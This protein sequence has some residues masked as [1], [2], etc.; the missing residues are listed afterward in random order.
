[1]AQLAEEVGALSE[2][3]QQVAHLKASVAQLDAQLNEGLQALSHRIGS[4]ELALSK[5]KESVERAMILTEEFKKNLGRLFARL[6]GV[7]ERL[8]LLE[9]QG[10][11][12][13]G[14]LGELRAW[15][16]SQLGSLAVRLEELESRLMGLKELMAQ[17]EG[18]KG[19]FAKL[20]EHQAKLAARQEHNEAQL[21]Q[22]KERLVVEDPRVAELERKVD[23]L[24]EKLAAVLIEVEQSRLAITELEG[25]LEGLREEIKAEVLAEIPPWPQVPTMEELRLVAEEVAAEQVKRAQAQAEAAQGLAIVALLA[26][27]AAIAVSLLL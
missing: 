12:L 14:E 22:L 21:A 11:A 8:S 18:L 26:G 6:E 10:D 23:K 1:V 27:L 13:Q 3:P 17:V 20:Q 7:E 9:Q 5:L 25:R 19:L 4:N 15:A 24:T 2:L 16:E